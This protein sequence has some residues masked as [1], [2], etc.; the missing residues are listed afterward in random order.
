M[1]SIIIIGG[2]PIGLGSLSPPPA[3]HI[4]RGATACGMWDLVAMVT[5]YGYTCDV[6]ADFKC[7]VLY[8][9]VCTTVQYTDPLYQKKKK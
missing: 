3:P 5:M 7:R 1:K 6:Y 4:V 9:T 2:N 8:C